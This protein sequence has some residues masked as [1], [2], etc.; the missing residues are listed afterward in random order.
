MIS[1]SVVTI[2]Q[3]YQAQA[4]GTEGQKVPFLLQPAEQQRAALKGGWGQ[5]FGFGWSSLLETCCQS[6]AMQRGSGHEV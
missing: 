6:L 5:A 3:C 4:A 2:T 1:V